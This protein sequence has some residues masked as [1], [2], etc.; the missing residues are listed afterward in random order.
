MAQLQK[1][2]SF[3]SAENNLSVASNNPANLRWAEWEKD[4]GG[5]E[6][7]PGGFTTFDTV[8]HAL[9]AH[10]HLLATVY[11]DE[12]DRRDWPALVGKYAPKSEN[13]SDLYAR[14]MVEWSA[15]W[16]EKLGIT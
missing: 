14:Q 6:G 13:D 16:R 12:V 1:E 15:R 2:S 11:R 3:L 4:F 5:T 7:G 8:D 10:V 9:Q